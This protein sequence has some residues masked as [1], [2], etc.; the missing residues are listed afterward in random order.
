MTLVIHGVTN[1]WNPIGK[2]CLVCKA[3][4]SLEIR[5]LKTANETEIRCVSCNTTCYGSKPEDVVYAITRK[6]AKER[7][8]WDCQVTIATDDS[9]DFRSEEV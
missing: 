2:D 4:S 1:R 5:K 9:E 7:R 3:E 6:N 8:E